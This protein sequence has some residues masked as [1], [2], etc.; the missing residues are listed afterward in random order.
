M[1]TFRQKWVTPERGDVKLDRIAI[2]IPAGPGRRGGPFDQDTESSI[3]MGVFSQ[4]P[5]RRRR[6]RFVRFALGS[7]RVVPFYET[8]SP[9]LSRPSSAVRASEWICWA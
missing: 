8:T 6:T 9:S 4:S 3:R 2:Q 1:G 5:L 7:S